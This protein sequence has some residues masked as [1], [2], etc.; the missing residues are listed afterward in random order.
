MTALLR[1]WQLSLKNSEI[2]GRKF[3]PNVAP[4]EV[5]VPWASE[6]EC[7]LTCTWPLLNKFYTSY[8]HNKHITALQY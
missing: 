6:S 4:V 8:Q 5:E 2:V 3:D 1:S 7:V